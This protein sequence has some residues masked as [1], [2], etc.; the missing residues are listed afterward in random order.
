MIFIK[1]HASVFFVATAIA[2]FV[3]AIYFIG[4]KNNFFNSKLAIKCNF[5]DVKGVP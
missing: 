2:I 5:K 4:S 3:L 1:L